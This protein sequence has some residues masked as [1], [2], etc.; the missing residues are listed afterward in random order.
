MSERAEDGTENVLGHRLLLL[1]VPTLRNLAHPAQS[2]SSAHR[3]PPGLR[4]P[5][6]ARL[7]RHDFHENPPPG[8][9]R[10][11][12]AGL[13][14]SCRE[15]R[16]YANRLTPWRPAS[17]IAPASHEEKRADSTGSHCGTGVFGRSVEGARVRCAPAVYNGSNYQQDNLFALLASSNTLHGTRILIM[18]SAACTPL[19]L[20]CPRTG[21]GCSVVGIDSFPAGRPAE[22]GSKW[23]GHSGHLQRTHG[24]LGR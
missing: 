19:A 7:N 4:P 8:S 10:M 24:L 20:E 6:D 14:D 21:R 22:T 12:I 13:D 3:P 17:A 9:V 16:S 15:R 23:S 2:A 1:V 11:F 5:A 18:M